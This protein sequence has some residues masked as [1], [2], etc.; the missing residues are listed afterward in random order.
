[1]KLWIVRGA[2]KYPDAELIRAED[3]TEARRLSDWGDGIGA[4]CFE[5]LADGEAGRLMYDTEGVGM[6]TRPGTR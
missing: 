1:M 3:E 5:L 6:L 2:G 4:E